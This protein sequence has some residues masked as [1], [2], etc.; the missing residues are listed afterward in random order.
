MEGNGATL[1]LWGPPQRTGEQMF[2]LALQR[3]YGDDTWVHGVGD[4]APWI[5]QQ[6]ASVFPRQRFLLDRYHLLEHLHEGASA[7]S[8]DDA[9]AAR[10]WVGVQAS[11]ID[12]GEVSEV[13]AEC[14]SRSGAKV[15]HPLYRLAGIL[16][17]PAGTTGL[18]HRPPGKDCPSAAARWKE[19]IAR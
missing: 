18:R 11:R 16:G 17:E 1:R 13:V 10:D 5:A 19:G 15:G 2:A 6:M 9:A 12:Q 8:P 14:R 4:G 7:L 3:G